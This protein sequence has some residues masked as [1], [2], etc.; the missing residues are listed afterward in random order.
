MKDIF[1]YLLCL[2]LLLVIN[3]KVNAL[4]ID[5]NELNIAPNDKELIELYANV[6]NASKV[7]FNLV[8]STYDIP[9]DFIVNNEYKEEKP[10]GIK[11]IVIFN[12]VK[13]GKVL[14]GTINISVVNKPK[15][16]IGSININ[17]AK[18]YDNEDN[19]KDLNNQ[20]ITVNIVNKEEEKKKEIIDKNLLS[21]IESNIVNIK[22]KNDIYNY[23]IEIDED[24]LEL[25]LK[26]IAKDS[27]T[28]VSIETQKIKELTDNKLIIKTKNNNIE[29]D[30]IINIKIN[31]NEKQ[32]NVLLI[33][34]S[35]F[36]PDNSYKSK[37]KILVIISSVVVV[38]SSIITIKREIAIK[39]YKHYY[40]K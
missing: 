22:L 9:A 16:L 18:A 14:L 26:P 17:S 10:N 40:I 1:K 19:I 33:D 37:W 21:K 13:N 15:D 8:F 20:S 35:E 3:I 6:E 34:K 11:H 4:S 30:Y 5:K 24:I 7:E 32:E 25:D 38:I 39:K 27:N 29:Q 2:L 12:E 31:K 36:K 28:L 23:N